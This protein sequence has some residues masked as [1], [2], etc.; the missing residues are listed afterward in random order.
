MKRVLILLAEGVEPLELSALT[1]TLGWANLVGEE[2]IEVQCVGLRKEINTTFG[3]KLV[4]ESTLSDCNLDEYDAIAIPGGF[5]PSGFYE[6]ALSEEFLGVIRYFH[7]R[8]KIVASVCVSSICLGQAG[9]LTGR[10]AT[11]YH[12]VGGAR[13]VQLE[14]TG[15][16][17]LDRP[18]VVD[19]NTITSSGPG[20]AIEV[21]LMLVERL[22][23]AKNSIFI[24]EKMRV[25]P[26]Q[27][28]WYV[29]PQVN[30]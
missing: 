13:K 12:Q 1:D 3:L 15:A 29:T 20:T 25:P 14:K 30:D 5:E 21:A 28:S 18:I 19:G 27:E 11:V 8:E 24:R 17:F 6:E 9:V 23:T 26:P 7:D 4:L 2:K 22:T 16:V 10:F